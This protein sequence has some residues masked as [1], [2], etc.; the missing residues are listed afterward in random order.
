MEILLEGHTDN[1]GDWQKNVKLSEDRVLEVKK[2]LHSKGTVS[3][4][5]L[6]VYKRQTV[7]YEAC[8]HLHRTVQHIRELG[9][10]PGVALNLSL[11]HI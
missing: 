6:D 7:H 3:Y 11:I 4:T 1:V 9:A 2:Y 5:H 10:L 8:T